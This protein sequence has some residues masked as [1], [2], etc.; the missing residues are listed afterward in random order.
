MTNLRRALVVEDT[1]SARM[2]VTAL[3]TQQGFDV[4]TAEDGDTGLA[5]VRAHDP[6]LIVLD[7]GL[8]GTD[9]ISACKQ[10][11]DFSDAYVLM[12]T[13]HDSELDKVLGFDAGADD[14]ITKPFSTPEF[15]ARV[16]ALMRRPRRAVIATVEPGLRRF[17]NLTVDPGAR[18]ATLDGIPIKLTKRE[19]D[20]LDV[21]SAQPRVAFTRAQ[22]LER[23]WGENWFGDDHLV[24]VHVSNLRRK[25]GDA[26]RDLILT[27]RGIGFRMGPGRT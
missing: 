2:L 15:L 18:E 13:G 12:L 7:V 11:R 6:E 8:P 3:L 23:V 4:T 24:S 20:L 9:G 27:V 19:F 14:Y 26:G 1:A 22:L 5:V 16:T 21:L 25:L 17:G 10:L